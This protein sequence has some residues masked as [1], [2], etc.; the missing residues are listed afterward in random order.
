MKPEPTSSAPAKSIRQL[1][2]T[3]LDVFPASLKNREQIRADVE[4][5][6]TE[7]SEGLKAPPFRDE[8]RMTA[9][10]VLDFKIGLESFSLARE[11]ERDASAL[12]ALNNLYAR[13]INAG[14]TMLEQVKAE[15]LESYSATAAID[16]ESEDLIPY[17]AET[18]F[19]CSEIG[20]RLIEAN[21][22]HPYGP[23][24]NHGEAIFMAGW[25][26]RAARIL[27]DWENRKRRAGTIPAREIPSHPAAA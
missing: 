19:K 25:Y 20:R 24:R 12:A 7:K 15:A 27:Q 23:I 10:S 6:K 14:E 13:L 18:L 2:Q 11:D 16:C 21:V 3:Q 5:W 1:Y 4:R 22:E 26:D 8:K 9:L 17:A